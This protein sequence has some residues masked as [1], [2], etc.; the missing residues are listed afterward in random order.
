TGRG[1]G[2]GPGGVLAGR[3]RAGGGGVPVVEGVVQ[4]DECRVGGSG[5][6]GGRGGGGG[7][8]R[9]WWLDGDSFQGTVG[10]DRHDLDVERRGGQVGDQVSARVGPGAEWSDVA[11][12]RG[13]HG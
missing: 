9:G 10:V 7:G 6:G 5:G 2:E 13:P 1:G 8:G 4:D 11:G 3:L 12:D